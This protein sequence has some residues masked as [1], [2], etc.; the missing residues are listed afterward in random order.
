MKSQSESATVDTL[1]ARA[2]APRDGWDYLLVAAIFAGIG[3]L[4][5]AALA[6]PLLQPLFEVARREHWSML[7]VRPTIIWVSMGLVLLV[8]RTVLWLVYRPFAAAREAEA[9]RLTVL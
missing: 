4:A 3:A 5:Y 7:W 9:P 1:A 8:M 6:T 2:W